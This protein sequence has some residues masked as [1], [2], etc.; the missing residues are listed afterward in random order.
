MLCAVLGCVFVAA[1]GGS[2]NETVAGPGGGDSGAAG[3]VATGGSDTGAA[4]NA[5]SGGSAAQSN[6]GGGP[7]VGTAGQGG[8]ATISEGPCKP[9][10][11]CGGNVVGTW[12][13]SELC[14]PNLMST[15]ATATCPGEMIAVSALTENGTY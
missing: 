11:A 8:G 1:C 6:T 4:G 5:A 7:G 3:N 10:T 2:S 14:T 13:A 9:I 15:Q 12:R